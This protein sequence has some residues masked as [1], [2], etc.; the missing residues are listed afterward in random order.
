MFDAE[1]EGQV[2]CPSIAMILWVDMDISPDE[3]FEELARRKGISDI[4]Y[5]DFLCLLLDRQPK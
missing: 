2:L 4:D 1:I 5:R 3:I